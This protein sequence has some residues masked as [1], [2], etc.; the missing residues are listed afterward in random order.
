MYLNFKRVH[1]IFNA[2]RNVSKTETLQLNLCWQKELQKLIDVKE[3]SFIINNEKKFIYGGEL[4]YFR[5]HKKDWNDRIRKVKEAGCNLISTYIPWMWHESREGNIDLTG[6]S[7]PERD[8]K[9]FLEM[10]EEQDMY[11]LVRPGP[12]IMSELKNHGIPNWIN[13]N[14]P[15]V[16]AKKQNGEDHPTDVVSYLHP[17]FI[18]KVDA[19]YHEVYK[20]ITPMQVTKGKNIIMVQLDNEVGMLQWVTNQADYNEDT[21]KRFKEYIRQ[22]YTLDELKSTLDICIDRYEDIIDLIKS[23]SQS[24]A[25]KLQNELMLF[26]REYYKEYIETLK[27]ISIKYGIEVPFVVN[28][29]GFDSVEYAKRGKKYPIGL[30]QLYEALKSEK[31]VAAGDYYIGNIV[32]ENYHDI[33]LA[34][35]FTKAVQAPEQPLFSAEF[36]GGFQYGIPRLQPTTFDLTTRLCIANGMNSLNYYMFVG[37]ENYE[38]IGLLGKRHDWQAPVGTDGTLRQ[39]YYTIKYLGEVIKAVEKDLLES[40]RAIAT[41]IG[42]YADYYMTEYSN[43]F[44]REMYDT[45]RTFREAFLYGGI[46]RGLTL[47]NITY[48]GYDVKK[49]GKIDAD[50]IKS[51]W[52]LSTP[53]MDEEVQDRLVQYAKDGGKLVLFPAIP[54]MDMKGNSCTKLLEALKVEIEESLWH[55]DVNIEGMDSVGGGYIEIYKGENIQSFANLQNDPNKICAFEKDLEKGKIVML[56]VGLELDQYF[57]DEIVKRVAA[58]VDSHPA[59]RRNDYIDVSFRKIDKTDTKFMF[60][61]NYDEYE[62]SMSFDYFGQPLFDGCKVTIAPRNG[63]ILALNYKINEKLKMIYSTCE[64]ISKTENEIEFFCKQNIEAMK[65]NNKVEVITPKTDYETIEQD[66]NYKITIKNCMNK[67]IK[68][69]VQDN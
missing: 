53:W 51:L 10:V 34:N 59:T 29:H 61:Q 18:E 25:V 32:H 23:S 63:L 2:S 45:L 56:G 55:K 52:M 30:S 7:T 9:S 48:E 41:Y 68:L 33:T 5:I 67:K 36:Q 1:K 38:N 42:F 6:K 28:V 46:G 4:H 31:V 44:T 43:E 66:G 62:K 49:N 24:C 19:W 58:R 16:V 27:A 60:I 69:K 57:K 3:Q 11:C 50:K 21:L 64:L 47:N 26:M 35:A 15:E 37:G 39:H 54:I 65:F 12:Y 8:L 14:Y 17:K 22:K 20:I 40:K 13:N